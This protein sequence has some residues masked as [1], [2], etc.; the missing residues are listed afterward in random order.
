MEGEVEVVLPGLGLVGGPELPLPD[1]TGGA[2][3]PK[4]LYKSSSIS[5][6][7]PSSDEEAEEEEDEAG[8][9][10]NCLSGWRRGVSR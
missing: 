10:Y 4:T 2:P 9:G 6:L 5:S 3:M 8:L 7:A 1:W